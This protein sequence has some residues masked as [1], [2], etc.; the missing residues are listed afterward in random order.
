MD[1]QSR[2]RERESENSYLNPGPWP[3]GSTPCAYVQS[4]MQIFELE[5]DWREQRFTERAAPAGMPIPIDDSDAFEMFPDRWIYDRFRIAKSQDLECGL[6]DVQP[7]RYPVFCKRVMN[8]A[9]AATGRIVY[10]EREYREECVDGDFWMP[11]L[12]GEHVSSDFALIQGVSEWSRH[13][14]GIRSGGG[15]RDQWIVEERQRPGLERY[16]QQWLR[17]NLPAYTGMVN[18]ESIGGRIVAAHL[19]CADQW[20]DLYGRKWLDAV[21]RLYRSGTWDLV[22]TGRAEGYSVVLFGPRRAP[23]VH[24]HPDVLSACRASVG[25]SSIQ[26]PFVDDPNAARAIWRDGARRAVVNSFNLEEALRV[27]AVLA[28][29]MGL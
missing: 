6:R 27:R 26:L 10:G 18:V 4:R 1:A 2:R 8:L 13:T 15:I 11:V 7:M 9:G 20:P 12:S 14:L 28:S 16:C 19:R 5:R 17:A 21:I 22:D 24:P 25:I 3:K 29:E 23:H